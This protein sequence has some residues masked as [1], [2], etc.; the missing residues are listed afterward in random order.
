M[1]KAIEILEI[2]IMDAEEMNG[3]LRKAFPGVLFCS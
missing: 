3:V 1:A 2:I